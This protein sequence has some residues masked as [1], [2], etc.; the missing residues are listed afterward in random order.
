LHYNND[1]IMAAKHFFK[2]DNVANLFV[3]YLQIADTNILPTLL[4]PF[5]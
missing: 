1:F 4:F 5:A 3:F 2:S